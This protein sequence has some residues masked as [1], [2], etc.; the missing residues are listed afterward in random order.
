MKE[1]IAERWNSRLVETSVQTAPEDV[2]VLKS[3][4]NSAWNYF[5]AQKLHDIVSDQW[6][7]WL[8]AAEQGKKI[9]DAPPHLFG[10][11]EIN[12]TP[13]HLTVLVSDGIDRY[14]LPDIRKIDIMS[15]RWLVSQK[16]NKNLF[17][18]ATTWKQSVIKRREIDNL[19]LNVQ[20][21]AIDEQPFEEQ[22]QA[23]INSRQMPYHD[24][25]PLVVDDDSPYRRPRW[26]EKTDL[27]MRYYNI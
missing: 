23:I 11:G 4:Y 3:F 13:E 12:S 2:L 17:D 27:E 21:V 20:D 25:P 18:L 14:E 1:N 15:R 10:A 24:P 7:R 8:K 9:H 19:T 26:N 5:S 22:L 6:N 16:R